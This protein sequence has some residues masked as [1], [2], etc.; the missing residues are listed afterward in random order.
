[1]TDKDFN[2]KDIIF[3]FIL[4]QAYW[5]T[6]YLKMPMPIKY[7]IVA[8]SVLYQVLSFKR[9]IAILFL[10]I[11]IPFISGYIGTGLLRLDKIFSLI[12]VLKY[13]NTPIQQDIII[14]KQ[15]KLSFILILVL[16][17]FNTMFNLKYPNF[18]EIPFSLQNFIADYYNFIVLILL[19]LALFK[20]IQNDSKLDFFLMLII[21]FSVS[22]ASS[23]IHMII[24][25]PQDLY[26]ISST[27]IMWNNEYFSHKNS[28][29]LY[30]SLLSLVCL[31]FIINNDK[32]KIKT[33]FYSIVFFISIL[34]L[35]LSLSRRAM[36]VFIAGIL[37]LLK[38]Q[39]N[40]KLLIL[41]CL[42]LGVLFV[43]QPDFLIQRF[44]SLFTAQNFNDLQDASAGQLQDVALEQII[45]RISIVPRF[46]TDK[47]EYNWMEG[48]WG[49]LLFRT[50]II[51]FLI[52][53]IFDIQ[54]LIMK[55]NNFPKLHII[56][57]YFFIFAGWGYRHGFLCAIYGQFTYVNIL[58]SYFI[59]NNMIEFKQTI[60]NLNKK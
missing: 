4:Y 49:Q 17:I 37:Y 38:N 10:S 28:W 33:I 29:G 16:K 3:L 46:F 8:I 42:V 58:L 35:V 21:V 22:M 30:F 39:F 44:D 36:F 51:G 56:I 1:M 26:I 19:F 13:F 45:H 50:G 53:L 48:F 24:N 6:E 43:W 2:F 11:F 60:K 31:H 7:V 41:I 34:V 52:F 23:L 5:L 47:W 32:T 40:I 12:F 57:S 55:K 15:L 27:S 25:N 14:T 9:S 59:F 20:K 18:T 54:L